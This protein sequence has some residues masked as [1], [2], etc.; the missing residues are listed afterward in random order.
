MRFKRRKPTVSWLPTLGQGPD[1]TWLPFIGSL[2][3]GGAA[4]PSGMGTAVA[5]VV[6]DYPAEAI[7]ASAGAGLPS[8]ADF[9]GSGYRLKRIVGKLNVG[10]WQQVGDPQGAGDYPTSVLVSAGFIVLR[11]TEDTGAPLRAATPNDYSPL[12][13]DNVRDPW[14]WRRSWRLAN[15]FGQGPTTPILSQSYEP[16]V[17]SEY[18]SAVD[19]PNIDARTAR[20]I[21]QEERLFFCISAMNIA[22]AAALAGTIEWCLDVRYLCSPMRA[23]GNRR[24]ASR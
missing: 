14:I 23:V 1:S 21:G 17:N 4:G 12:D 18:G 24:N 7:R 20:R 16:V 9:E 2:G 19:G 5:A 11:V 13:L 8:L 10:I 6:P 15:E 3:F 22:N